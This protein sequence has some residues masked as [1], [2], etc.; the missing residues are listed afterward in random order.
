MAS[1]ET[2]QDVEDAQNK[3]MAAGDDERLRML[4]ADEVPIDEAVSMATL[5]TMAR[6]LRRAFEGVK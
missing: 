1:L 4:A 6:V 3:F 5:Q 2:Y